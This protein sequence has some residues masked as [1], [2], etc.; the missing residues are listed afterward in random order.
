MK[1][2]RNRHEYPECLRPYSEVNGIAVGSC[3]VSPKW[4]NNTMAHAHQPWYRGDNH[5]P[6]GWIC[7]SDPKF[8]E[9]KN[10]LLHELAHLRVYDE[11]DAHG[12]DWRYEVLKL[13]G[14]LKADGCGRSYYKNPIKRLL[15]NLFP[16]L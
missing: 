14:T 3:I 4:D 2:I 1:V 16:N 5:K 15:S 11:D 9:D 6:A 8:L 7:L 12:D 10:T 13:G